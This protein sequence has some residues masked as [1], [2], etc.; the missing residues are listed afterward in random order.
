MWNFC[1]FKHHANGQCWK[2]VLAACPGSYSALMGGCNGTGH[3]RC[4]HWFD[5]STAIT[6][7]AGGVKFF[8]QNRKKCSSKILPNTLK[9]PKK[10]VLAGCTLWGA[11]NPPNLF[12]GDKL[13]QN[14]IT[15]K[16]LIVETWFLAQNLQFPFAMFL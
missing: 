15:R 8:F 12:R 5:T 4:C 6:A 3:A 14:V 13:P 11:S 16:P 10:L 7:R 9:L 1:K 2:T